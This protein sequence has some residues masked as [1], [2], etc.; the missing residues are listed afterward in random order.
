M[1]SW[2][3]NINDDVWK[4]ARVNFINMLSHSFYAQR[5][6]KRKK[7]AKLSVEKQLTDLLCSCTSEDLRFMLFAQDWWNWPQVDI[8]FLTS[9]PSP[10]LQE[11]VEE[12]RRG[13]LNG[14]QNGL[15]SATNTAKF[16]LV[17]VLPN[18]QTFGWLVLIS[19]TF[20]CISALCYSFYIF[21]NQ[22]ENHRTR[23]HIFSWIKCY[24]LIASYYN[25]TIS[26]FF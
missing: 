11:R 5:S 10:I 2:K 18:V 6:Q 15:N 17:I 8:K 1:S 25:I 13:L 21:K 16:V 24:V 7:T 22:K 3:F 20:V 12:D 19:Y 23:E 9:I 4:P 26:P 14:V